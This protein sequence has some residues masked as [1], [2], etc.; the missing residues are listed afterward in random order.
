MGEEVSELYPDGDRKPMILIKVPKWEDIPLAERDSWLKR[1]FG[2]MPKR[3]TPWG[4]QWD[5]KKDRSHFAQVE[6]RADAVW[7]S[8]VI[9]DGG[10]KCVRYWALDKDQYE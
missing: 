6:S 10:G 9:R 3:T 7:L 4:V 8:G 5:D 1:A 2:N